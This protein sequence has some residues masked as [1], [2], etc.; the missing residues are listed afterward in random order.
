MV[1][2]MTDFKF[3]NNMYLVKINKN[4][5]KMLNELDVSIL[6]HKKEID[7]QHIGLIFF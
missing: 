4:S 1:K 6:L 2:A 5:K 7:M 3:W